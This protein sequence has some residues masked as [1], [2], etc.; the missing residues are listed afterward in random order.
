MSYTIFSIFLLFSTYE[1]WKIEFPQQKFIT[2]SRISPIQDARGCNKIW[3]RGTPIDLYRILSR[4]RKKGITRSK[5]IYSFGLLTYVSSRECKWYMQI[6]HGKQTLVYG[7]S[8]QNLWIYSQIYMS[9]LDCTFLLVRQAK[10]FVAHR[11]LRWCDVP[12]L[13]Y[14]DSKRPIVVHRLEKCN[15]PVIRTKALITHWTNKS[16]MNQCVMCS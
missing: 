2:Y 1:L 5:L 6:C 3:I 8:M 4:K 15:V 9:H 7:I 12:K 14:N 11:K 10:R 16:R 13:V